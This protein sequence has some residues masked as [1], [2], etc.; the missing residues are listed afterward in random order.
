MIVKEV[1]T[2]LN[3]G[4][5]HTDMSYIKSDFRQLS[6]VLIFQAFVYEVLLWLWTGLLIPV[7]VSIS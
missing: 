4:D 3:C 6:K 2:V 7:V 5:S 1:K